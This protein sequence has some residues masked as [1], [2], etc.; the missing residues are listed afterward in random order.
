MV[1]DG[2]HPIAARIRAPAVGPVTWSLTIPH[3][4]MRALPEPVPYDGRILGGAVRIV[5]GIWVVSQRGSRIIE[6]GPSKVE[7]PL[8]F[9][10]E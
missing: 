9:V 1:L 4:S 6:S 10:L 8:R 5:A 7:E 3:A 2:D